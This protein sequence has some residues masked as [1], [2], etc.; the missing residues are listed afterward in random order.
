MV[1]ERANPAR[2]GNVNVWSGTASVKAKS[3]GGEAGHL[4]LQHIG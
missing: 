2:E 1:W 3:R 4:G